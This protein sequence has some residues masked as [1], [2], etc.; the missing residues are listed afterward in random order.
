[1]EN[2][3]TII[4]MEKNYRP[5]VNFKMKI[6]IQGLM[7]LFDYDEKAAIE[8]IKL[9]DIYPSYYKG[10]DEPYIDLWDLYSMLV[11]KDDSI[12]KYE[13]SALFVVLNA[14]GVVKPLAILLTKFAIKE[15]KSEVLE[16]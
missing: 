3:N 9:H 2:P 11:D 13:L 12:E 5:W 6:V 15:Y 14:M 4:E 1:M 8:S 16:N 10:D 7:H